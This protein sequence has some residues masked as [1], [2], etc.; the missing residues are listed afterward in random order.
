MIAPVEQAEDGEHLVVPVQ[1]EEDLSG[2][3]TVLVVEDDETS[4]SLSV[5]F[6]KRMKYMKRPTGEKDIKKRW[7]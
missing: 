2:Y 1:E 7:N 6:S 4:G 3:P 5:R